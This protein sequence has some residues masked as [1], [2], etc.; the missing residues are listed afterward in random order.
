MQ[1]ISGLQPAL[2]QLLE[3][4]GCRL[5]ALLLHGALGEAVATGEFCAWT[6][7]QACLSRLVGEALGPWHT[8]AEGRTRF[9]G[10]VV[11]IG[12]LEPPHRQPQ[13]D[14]RLQD[15]QGAEAPRPALLHVGAARLASATHEGL[16]AALERHIALR[17]ATPLSKHTTC[18]ETEH[19]FETMAIHAHG[20]L[21]LVVFFWRGF[22]SIL[23]GILCLSISGSQPLTI[24]RRH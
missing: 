7:P 11:A 19:R 9:P 5:I 15:G 23:R 3:V 10:A 8:R 16:I 18:W 22:S 21:R 17:G 20:F 24:A 2:A 6:T 1:L 14:G 13:D 12:A 4:F